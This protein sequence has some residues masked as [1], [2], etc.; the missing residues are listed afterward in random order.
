M[1]AL[2]LFGMVGTAAFAVTGALVAL[3]RDMDIL[4]VIV[5]GIVAA[6]G[7]GMLR[8]VLMGDYPLVFL[9]DARYLVISL[10]ASVV[11]FYLRK[12]M[13]RLRKI[14]LVADAIGLGVFLSIGLTMGIT[15]GYDWWASILL[16]VITATFG[17]VLRDMLA[18]Q[19]PLIFQKELYA[20]VALAAGLLYIGL[21]YLAVSQ[22][23][24][25]TATTVFAIGFR[26]LAIRYNWS[27]PR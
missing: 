5:L 20:T 8:S 18:A 26:L 7:G 6:S 23:V 13:G 2:T 22:A 21:S 25:I 16:G 17:G 14:I 9:S 27:L 3:R 19:V 11:V 15:A 10:V 24:V 4:G 1:E 12:L